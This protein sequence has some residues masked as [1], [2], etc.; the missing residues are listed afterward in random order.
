MKLENQKYPL[1]T[2]SID[3]RVKDLKV[4]NREGTRNVIIL[5]DK[6]YAGIMPGDILNRFDDDDSVHDLKNYFI[7]LFLFEDYTLFDWLKVKERLDL[8]FIPLVGKDGI[9]EGQVS[10]QDILDRFRNTGLIVDL[11]SILVIRKATEDFSYSEVFQIA[12]ANGAKIFASYIQDSSKDYTVIALN[13][14]HTGL[15]ELLQSFRRYEYDIISFHD[16]D[17][18]HE[19]LKANSDYFSKY[20]TV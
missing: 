4:L 20:L 14:Y 16:E 10:S 11:S 9:F 6:K 8:D 15:N 13:I 5:D 2:L 19:T 18:H 1:P 17:L 3:S 12:E 7:D